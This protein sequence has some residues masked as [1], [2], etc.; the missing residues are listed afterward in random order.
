[1]KYLAYLLSITS[2]LLFSSCEG[3]EGPVGPQGPSGPET[4][5]QIYEI[6][7]IDFNTSNEFSYFES[8]ASSTN[9][10]I[11]DRDLVLI[12][13]ESGF[14]E[15]TGE[16]TW[17]LLPATKLTAQGTLH[18]TFEHT[19]QDFVI[20]FESDFNLADINETDE[21]AFLLDQVF[22]IAI[23]PTDIAPNPNSAA[24]TIGGNDPYSY[25]NI[26]KNAIIFE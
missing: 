24:K 19:S 8:F 4:L 17:E 10:N 20:S 6:E 26:S 11:L 22:R 1:M 9:L 18:Y 3:P 15:E 16:P 12:Y 14:I 7:N 21:N 2:I 13:R 5:T 23:V 25:E